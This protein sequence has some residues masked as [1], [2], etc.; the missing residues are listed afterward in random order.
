M[1]ALGTGTAN[2]GK[3]GSEAW[4]QGEVRDV[5]S[6]GAGWAPSPRPGA[7]VLAGPEPVG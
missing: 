3:V 4:A 7:G 2:P 6:T 5:G 1:R